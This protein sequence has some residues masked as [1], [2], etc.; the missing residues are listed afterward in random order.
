[1]V[2]HANG[3]DIYNQNLTLFLRGE[4]LCTPC[5]QIY[6]R[7]KNQSIQTMVCKLENYL[8]VSTLQNIVY[9]VNN[10]QQNLLGL[11]SETCRH[12][13]LSVFSLSTI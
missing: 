13:K 12:C 9:L 5:F 1:M 8:L 3:F 11:S 10:G 7:I 6:L 2:R 4:S